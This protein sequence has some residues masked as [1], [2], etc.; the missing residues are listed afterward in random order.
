MVIKIIYSFATPSS[1]RRGGEEI[2][3]SLYSVVKPI[4]IDSKNPQYRIRTTNLKANLAV[5]D[6]LTKYPLFG[7]KFLDFND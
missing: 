1:P 2:A 3:I 5:V 6:Y 7:T 4:R